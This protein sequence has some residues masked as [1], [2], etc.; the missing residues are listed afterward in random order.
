MIMTIL[1]W[2]LATAA[3]AL[4]VGL[5]TTQEP[6]PPTGRVVERA[7]GAE[8]HVERFVTADGVAWKEAQ[9][10]GAQAKWATTNE[11]FWKAN[12]GQDAGTF[13]RWAIAK[14]LRWSNQAESDD[15]GAA[16][17]VVEPSLRAHL[18]LPEGQGLVVI[19]VAEN[20]RAAKVGLKPNDIL[21]I[22]ADKPLAK[23]EDLLDA[24]KAKSIHSEGP[25]ELKILRG[26]KPASVKVKGELRAAL[27]PVA[28]DAVV[29]FIG[30]PANPLDATYRAHLDV[31]EG[32]GLIVGEIKDNTPAAKAGIK[33]G[34][35]L[36]LFDGNALPDV[37]TLRAKIQ[38]KGP[39]PAKIQFLRGGHKQEVSVT[40]ERRAAEPVSELPVEKYAF[41]V[42][43]ADPNSVAG[44]QFLN[45]VPIVNRLF[46]N[47]TNPQ[48]AVVADF[49]PYV[50][51]NGQPQ[52][53]LN[54]KIDDLTAQVAALTKAV[55]ALRAGQ[56][57][58]K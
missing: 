22:L 48:G 43:R 21:L 29:F 44:V 52:A 31:P 5:A 6:A 45:N 34:D 12:Q 10:A 18:A 14:D 32:T 27:A 15:I 54:K 1:G 58:K 41:D 20:G 53:D 23:P 17:A 8:G 39:H 40:P 38:G 46:V 28:E 16:L 3:P 47:G 30:T 42:V 7:A 36:L 9:D 4:A 13:A 2:I 50:A 56:A 11:V 37:D 51:A 55:E 19:D 35:I 33:Q 57:T 25:L 24:L 49:Q 26:G